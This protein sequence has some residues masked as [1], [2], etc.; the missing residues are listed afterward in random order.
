MDRP[1]ESSW[2]GAHENFQAREYDAGQS[3]ASQH[4]DKKQLEKNLA[5]I[6]KTF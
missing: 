3:Q 4:E 5:Q 6:L 2:T 1:C